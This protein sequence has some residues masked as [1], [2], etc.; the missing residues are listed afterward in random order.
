FASPRLAHR[1]ARCAQREGLAHSD[2]RGNA[3]NGQ[4]AVDRRV[5]FALNWERRQ[6]WGKGLSR[7][8]CH[9]HTK[10][11]ARQ[12]SSTS[13]AVRAL[14]YNCGAG[15][16]AATGDRSW[17]VIDT[18]CARFFPSLLLAVQCGEA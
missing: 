7:R 6:F 8:E 13:S 18:R 12:R 14:C 16:N 11:S 17:E 4:R 1:K 15:E 10:S 9:D 2:A 5:V 3:A